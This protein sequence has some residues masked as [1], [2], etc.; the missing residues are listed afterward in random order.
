MVAAIAEEVTPRDVD[1]QTPL[2][3][4][5]HELAALDESIGSAAAGAGRT[6]LIE[7]APGIGKSRL[8]A[9]AGER[10]VAHGFRVLKTSGGEL[11]R[12]LGWGAVRE[13]FGH[14]L[15][16]TEP[17]ERED[18]L[19]DAAALARPILWPGAEPVPVA[20]GE[21]LLAT[22]LHG[23]YWL[24]V[25]LT[26]RVPLAVLVD[27]AHWTDPASLQFFAYLAQ[28]IG[29]LPLVF[30]LAAHGDA[31]Q[32]PGPLAVIAATARIVRPRALSLAATTE[33]LGLI[34][35]DP[36]APD[37]A[38][39][40]QTATAGNPFLVCELGHELQ[41]ERIPPRAENADR[42]ATLRPE[43]IGRSVLLR[44]S[45]VPEPAGR[46]AEAVAVLGLA[47]PLARAAALAGLS[48]QEAAD[49]A[50]ELAAAQILA[51]G[52]P[53]SFAHPISHAALLDEIAPVRRATLH[54]R[55]SELLSREGAGAQ[56]ALHLLA[57]DPRGQ[58]EAVEILRHEAGEALRRGAPESAVTLLRRALREPPTA[59]TLPTVLAE[60]ADAE[61]AAGCIDA[62]EHLRR[63]LELTD[64]PDERATLSLRLG[65]HLC[66]M[67]RIGEGSEVLERAL[68]DAGVGDE[69]ALELEAA[70]LAN[71]W[72]DS[73][74]AAA[75]RRRQNAFLRRHRGAR[76]PA[77]RAL[78]AQ[79][80][81]AELFAGEPAEDVIV[82]AQ[83]LLAD[84]GLL[85]E[86]GPDSL[87]PWIAIGC[88]SW[89]DAFDAA[90]EAIE[91]AMAE[92]R[93]RSS[94]VAVAQGFYARA[95]PRFWRGQVSEAAADA[96]AAIAG[97]RGAWEM[98]LP[99]AQ[100]WLA[101][102]R[103]ELDD[104]DAA[105]AALAL[106]DGDRW[107]GTTPHLQWRTG[108]ATLAI[109]RG[110][111]RAGLEE[112][113]EVGQQVTNRLLIKNPALLPWRALAATA[114]AQL[115][116]RDRAAALAG[117]ALALA[118]GFGAPRPI[119][120]ALRAAGLVEGGDAGLRLL[121]ESVDTLAR[122]PATLELCRSRIELGAALRRAGRRRDARAELGRGLEL[123]SRLGARRLERQ[124]REE[125]KASGAR[126]GRMERSGPESLT[127]SERRVAELAAAGST[128]RAIAQQLF[129]SLRTVETH[130][131]HA[132]QKLAI[133]S[134]DEL[135][136]ALA[137]P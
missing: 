97:W 65:W 45:R 130:L 25:N 93:R 35:D 132:Y 32:R 4:R 34:I 12:E 127:P 121:G 128:N 83:R 75:V 94:P 95:W 117:E 90:E 50:D 23:L 13:L 19:S 79:S 76:G 29:D 28:R 133:S 116:E 136:R 92:A 82:L 2:L 107:A 125:L 113:D 15:R 71:A 6:L 100:Y 33:L 58:Q 80:A 39:A 123:A 124:A 63:A 69:V 68:S 77:Q 81:L 36:A 111:L 53:L 55:A 37:F 7:G 24:S 74:R 48:D 22:A 26:E 115:G 84:P 73:S 57:A 102:A 99:A 49:A 31:T 135:A 67:G 72:Q 105:E 118:R 86:D 96:E 101:V 46:L 119:G 9:A 20:P 42:V 104:S 103:L 10:A 129:V 27:D 40:C 64:Q 21:P 18:V 47:V 85:A 98:Y 66:R 52:A 109:A 41:R 38:R 70:Y 44:L 14:G 1:G 62:I 131:T 114:A 108:R 60:L 30:A 54:G 59:A 122:S 8:L 16:Q 51:P 89:S 17:A 3:E 11:E 137:Q 112:L 126:L 56:A 110:D 120:I 5:E 61:A 87:T 106:P 91:R 134:R 43:A 78:I 88:L